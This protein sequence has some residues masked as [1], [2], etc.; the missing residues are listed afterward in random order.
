MSGVLITGYFLPKITL[1]ILGI[2]KF[3]MGE[4][5]RI[6]FVNLL[7]IL[8][9]ERSLKSFGVRAV[10]VQVPLRVLWERLE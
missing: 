2:T 5:I 4:H 6:L 1:A 7:I 8:I 9:Q 3:N 10:R